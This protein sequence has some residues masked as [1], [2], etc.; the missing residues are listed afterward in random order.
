MGTTK[1]SIQWVKGL[2]PGG[3]KWPGRKVNHFLPLMVEGKNE[4]RY[5]PNPPICLRILSSENL[6][7][8]PLSSSQLVQLLTICA[9]A[10]A[11]LSNLSINLTTFL[12]NPLNTPRQRPFCLLTSQ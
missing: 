11:S 6:S 5:T 8:T 12:D 3:I 4:R 1:P 2:L 10:A 7:F 9:G